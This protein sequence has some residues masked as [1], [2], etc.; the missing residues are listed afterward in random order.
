MNDI[1]KLISEYGLMIV[2]AAVFIWRVV[3]AEKRHA[4]ETKEFT[5]IAAS[6]ANVMSNHIHDS[7]VATQ[8]LT[9]AIER[10][11]LLVDVNHDYRKQ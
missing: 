3:V 1:V 2:I 10:L 11:C 9:K 8:E 4:E 7:Q 6:F 5:A